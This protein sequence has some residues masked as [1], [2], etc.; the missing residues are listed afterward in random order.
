MRME[1]LTVKAQ[2]AIQAAQGVADQHDHQALEPEHVL[3]A[4][5]QQREGVVGPLLAKLGARAETVQQQLEAELAR[6]PK[7]RGGGGGQY[8][9]DR[10][11]ATL[12]G[13]ER[14][15]ERFKDEYGSTEH[16]LIAIAQ[17][18]DGA[19]GRALAAAGVSS[20]AIY[21]AL[22]DV[23]GTQ[24][25]TDQN[26]E[27]KYQALQRYSR[28]LTEAARKGKLDPVIGRDEEI[29]RVVQVLSRRTKNNPVL[30]GEPGVGKT[31]IVEGLAQRIV[32]GDVP[33]GLKDKRLVAIDIGAMVAGSKYRGEFADRLTA[34]LKAITEAEG[35]IIWF[36]DERHTLVGAGAAEGAVDA[37]NMLKPALARGEL[38]CVG[39]TTL[40]EYRKHMRQEPAPERRIQPVMDR[41]PS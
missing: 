8:V 31:A 36:I 41:E 27:D 40:D 24:R 12:E 21:K 13:A 3:L 1:K 11:R 4:L 5:L 2:E 38:R 32:A 37:A 33:E 19:A 14:E 34:V 16:L 25:V 23:R 15:A 30:I 9:G 6:L 28:D 26:P 35:K 17:D 10:R 7:V 18:R 20:D 39:A 29:R 22:V